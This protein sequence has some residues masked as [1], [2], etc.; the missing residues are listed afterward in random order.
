MNLQ[1]EKPKASI[2][3]GTATIINEVTCDTNPDVTWSKNGKDIVSGGQYLMEIRKHN[4]NQCSLVLTIYHLK[5]EDHGTFVA[6]VIIS[7]MTFVYTYELTLIG[8]N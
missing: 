4:G 2:G 1:A 8:K 7:H 3:N 6:S 5:P